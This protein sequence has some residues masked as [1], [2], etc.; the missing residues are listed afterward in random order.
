MENNESRKDAPKET[1]NS[2]PAAVEDVPDPEEDDLD[3]L[4]G[5]NIAPPISVGSSVLTIIL[6]MLDE[7]SATKIDAPKEAPQPLKPR[8]AEALGEPDASDA[9]ANEFSKQLQDQMAA[10]M[11]NIDESPE[12]K[13][14]I[15]AMMRELGAATD[16]GAAADQPQVAATGRE[17]SSA[18]DKPF[19]KTIKKTMERMQASG[20]QATAAAKS[21]DSDDMLAQMLKG[22][23]DGGL[24]GAGD[25]EGFNKML[26]GM[27]EQLTNKDI[28][29]EPMKELHDKFPAWMTKN[30]NSTATDDLKRYEEQERLVGEIVGRFEQKGYSDSKADDREFIVE[31][32]QQVGINVFCSPDAEADDL[33]DASSWKSTC[34]SCRRYECSIRCSWQHRLWLRS[35]MRI[36]FLP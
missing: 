20:D 15:E 2:A 17:H 28:L 32:M 22:L 13:Q 19:H 30:R 26:M 18:S 24:E 10:L 14:E 27:M 34:R 16:P 3:D 6:D 25:E 36:V 12:M 8:P 7:F 1:C 5:I 9:A 23:Q 35:T 33:S 31:R 4:D 29:Y 11:G 21:D